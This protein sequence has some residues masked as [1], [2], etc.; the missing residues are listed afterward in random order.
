MSRYANSRRKRLFD[1]V[2]AIIGLILAAPIIGAAWLLIKLKSPGPGFYRQTRVGKDGKTFVIHKLRTMYHDPARPFSPCLDRRD[3]RITPVGYWLRR[4]FIDELPQF[5]N[6]IVGSMSLVG[7]RPRAVEEDQ[8]QA[9]KL[10]RYLE[11][12]QVKPGIFGLTKAWVPF[13]H[14]GTLAL[15]CDLIYV[16]EA[17]LA[18]DLGIIYDIL[19]SI[20]RGAPPRS[21]NQ[22]DAPVFVDGKIFIKQPRF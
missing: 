17:S 18:R 4:L 7:P 12:H 13:C 20:L 1:I 10:D 5:W 22:Y 11:R 15:G 19:L 21:T 6:V 8:A 16:Q 2:T 14:D 3:P 9:A